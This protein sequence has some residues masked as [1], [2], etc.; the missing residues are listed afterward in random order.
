MP[1]ATRGISLCSPVPSVVNGISDVGPLFRMPAQVP[2]RLQAG[3]REDRIHTR[4]RCRRIED[5]LRLPILLQPGVRMTDYDRTIRLAVRRHAQPED[6]K[7]HTK[8]QDGCPQNKKQD[9]EKDL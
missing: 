2:A 8:C 1:L 6:A 3:V 9:A 7:I 5:E 4:F